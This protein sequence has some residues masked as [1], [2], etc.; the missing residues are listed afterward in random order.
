MQKY[1]AEDYSSPVKAV[2]TTAATE[3]MKNVEKYSK[4]EEQQARLEAIQKKYSADD[5]G[6]VTKLLSAIICWISPL[7]AAIIGLPAAI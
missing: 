6:A 4:A 2:T 5:I 1:G 7:A 3:L